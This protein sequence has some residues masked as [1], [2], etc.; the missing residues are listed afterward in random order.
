M[1]LTKSSRLSSNN[2]VQE[3]HLQAL[4]SKATCQVCNKI[5][6]NPKTLPCLHSFCASCLQQ[7]D[8]SD[9]ERSEIRCPECSKIANVK[10]AAF[11]PNAFQ[12]LRDIAEYKFVQK[13]YGNVD[14]PCE[15]CTS[16]SNSKAT[17]FCEGCNRFVCNLCVT[18]HRSWSEFSSHKIVRISDLKENYRKYIP[19][20][21]VSSICTEHQKDCNLFCETCR[22]EVCHECIIKGH[23][24]HHYN[25]AKESVQQHKDVITKKLSSTADIP[26]HLNTAI[27]RL[28]TL[29]DKLEAMSESTTLR[30]K[31]TFD[32][33]EATLTQQ[34]K[35]LLG[36]VNTATT[37]KTELLQNQKQAL[38]KL[39]DN[40]VLCQDFV[41]KTLESDHISEFFTLEE[42]I[43]N[44]FTEIRDEFEATDLRP[45]EQPEVHFS[46]NTEMLTALIEVAHVSEG[47]VLHV[48]SP[49]NTGNPLESVFKLNEVVTF[50]IAFS[51]SF[52]KMVNDPSD[53]LSA[54]IK[55][56]RD[57][58]I[59]AATVVLNENGFAKIQCSFRERGRYLLC[60][61]ISDCHISGSPHAF[62]IKPPLEHF[63]T[64]VRSITKISNPSGIAVNHKNQVIVSQESNVITVYGRVF[65][66]VLSFGSLG[67]GEGQFNSPGGL[68]VDS[69]DHIYVADSKNNRIQKFDAQGNYVSE[70]M[71]GE[72]TCGQLN[73]PGG[74]KINKN[75]DIYIV[76]RGNCRIV[77]LTEAMEYKFTLG[78]PTQL[79]DPRDLTFDDD[80]CIYISDLK[81]NS[82][83][84]FQE[85]GEYR[86]RFG[87]T[88][89]QKGRLNRPSGVAIDRFGRLFI[90]ELANHRVSVFNTSSEFLEC[91]SAGLSMVNPCALTVD[92]DGFVYIASSDS[93]HIF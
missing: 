45:L 22:K 7:E 72:N 37:E 51:S 16:S 57:G 78:S 64:T 79:K 90:C 30:V 34:R 29:V 39:R 63:H 12:I 21:T 10:K 19:D 89:T 66:K 85:T 2:R 74:I 43:V 69:K 8:V 6:T 52:F 35:A 81:Q 60:V 58:S 25:L 55:Y 65:R 46:F 84:V 91:F 67:E 80:G 17:N 93:I 75:G 77:V 48:S 62:F 76:D 11:L 54:E 56:I 18:I 32:K 70:F 42:N 9:S 86:G 83:F 13:I 31:E 47:S 24:D 14:N 5:F 92:S 1:S 40:V 82:I 87:G 88:G 33:I 61:T 71:G 59:S 23:R 73:S 4:K 20:P 26:K 53:S 44:R 49:S 36:E 27:S 50:F 38:M 3:N 15:K 41:K 68:A 28:D